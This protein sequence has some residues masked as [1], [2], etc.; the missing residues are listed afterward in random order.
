MHASVDELYNRAA[1]CA[2]VYYDGTPEYIAVDVTFCRLCD[3]CQIVDCEHEPY[4]AHA[5]YLVTNSGIGAKGK[6][7]VDALNDLVSSLKKLTRSSVA[8]DE[9]RRRVVRLGGG[10]LREARAY[11]NAS[12]TEA[13][14]VIGVTQSR[15]LDIETGLRPFT[16]DMRRLFCDAWS[17][18]DI[19][20]PTLRTK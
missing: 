3:A 2:A 7:A 20:A 19:I 13:A 8:S 18:R 12:V 9:I 1:M 11:G 5:V 16:A 10:T 14:R 15:Y 6:T 4:H 17:V